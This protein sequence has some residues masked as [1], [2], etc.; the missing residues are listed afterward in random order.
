MESFDNASIPKG[1]HVVI[2]YCT[3][4]RLN[5]IK[6]PLILKFLLKA[7]IT[8]S[9]LKFMVLYVRSLIR[10]IMAINSVVMVIKKQ[11]KSLIF[12]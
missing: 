8:F 3:Q 4:N 2:H 5:S 12:N 1:R 9:F 10:I 6:M 7:S 11:I